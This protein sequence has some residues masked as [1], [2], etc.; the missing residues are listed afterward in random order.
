MPPNAF[1]NLWRKESE[2]KTCYVWY[3]KYVGIK[4]IAPYAANSLAGKCQSLA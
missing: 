3:K 2:K 4:E 1:P